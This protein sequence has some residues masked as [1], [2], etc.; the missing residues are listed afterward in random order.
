M[1]GNG[2]S[3]LNLDMQRVHNSIPPVEVFACNYAAADFPVGYCVMVD[4]KMIEML[5]KADRKGFPAYI[6]G[7]AELPKGRESVEIHDTPLRTMTE[8]FS[9][10]SGIKET[11]EDVGCSSGGIAILLAAALGFN[12]IYLSGFDMGTKNI[13]HGKE[14]YVTADHQ[15]ELDSDHH[16]QTIIDAL[17]KYKLK[18]TIYQLPPHTL[19]RFDWCSP[20]QIPQSWRKKSADSYSA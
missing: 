4:E 19:T 5:D 18:P 2:P 3:R 11:Y 8:I 9:K 7:R 1:L 10:W 20:E 12:P 14:G 13:Y 17:N 6:W 15:G 16:G